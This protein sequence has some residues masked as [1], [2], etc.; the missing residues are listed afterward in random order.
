MS[1]RIICWFSCGATSAVAAHLTLKNNDPSRVH[2]VYCDT[3]S[4][5]P[6]NARFLAD[7]ERWYGRKIEVI[8]S[9][10]YNNVDEVN[11]RSTIISNIYG[12]PCTGFLKRAPRLAYQRPD[13]VHIFGYHI[14]EQHRLKRFTEANPELTVEAPLIDAYLNHGD[15]L[16]LLAQVGIELP[17][18]YK[19][20]FTNNNCL[21]C[22]KADS[23]G[24]WNMTRTHFPEVFAR[25]AAQSRALGAKMVKVH[26]ERI[27]LDE[28]PTD[29]M[30]S[31]G[32]E[33][34]T[35]CNIFCQ[36]AIGE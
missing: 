8:K 14:K 24:Y 15:C 22:N 11:E 16:A 27:F 1:H 33:P 35:E 5:H 18:M 28:L 29:V 31:Y 9:T 26:G 12:A 23:P 21:G 4:E 36:I 30:G 25:R 32:A 6:D 7:C 13:D 20:G 10:E 17:T 2:V 3:G 34:A 19:L